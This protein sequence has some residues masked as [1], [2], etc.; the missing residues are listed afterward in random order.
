MAFSVETIDKNIAQML[1]L[2][3]GDVLSYEDYYRNLRELIAK[4]SF[5]SEKFSE[6]FLAF[7]VNERKRVAKKPGVFKTKIKKKSTETNTKRAINFIKP[8]KEKSSITQFITNQNQYQK[9][10]GT[11]NQ[12]S[13][14]KDS[15]ESIYNTL[16]RQ[17]NLYEKIA[18]DNRKKIENEKR[19][20]REEG[21][22]KV[23]FKVLEVAKKILAPF[24]SIFDKII[25][26]ISFIILGRS[27]KLF[28]D[29]TSD[30][31]NKKK[32][33]VLGRFLKDWW[34]ALLGTWF[35]FAHPI[36]RFVRTIIGTV[37]KLTFSLAKTAIPKLISFA[38]TN[39]LIASGAV[40]GIAAGAGYMME[41]NRIDNIADKQ[42]VNPEKR[43]QGNWWSE[44]GKSLNPGQLGMGGVS[45]L[46]KG[47]QI[48][49]GLVGRDTGTTVSGAGPDTQ[50]L[51]IAEGGGAVLQRG[52]VV[53]QKG[54]R[55]RMI[56]KV[57]VDPLAFNIG[58]NANK[59][60]NIG[61]NVLGSAY[62]GLV[63]FSNGGKIGG[64]SNLLKPQAKTIFDRLVK[65]GL[66]PTAAAGIVA[67]IGVETGYTYDPNT[68]QRGGGPGRGL[69]Q[70][71]KGGRFDTDRINLMSFAKSRGT[72]WNNLNTQVDFI[73]HELNTHPEYQKVKSKINKTKD[74]SS[75]T[76]IFLREYEKAGVPHTQDRMKVAQQIIKSGYLNPKEKDQKQKQ[77][78]LMERFS[79]FASNLMMGRGAYAKPQKRMGGGMIVE[80]NTGFN[81]P[82]AT[83][84]RQLLPLIGGGS[85][86]L[87]PG[88]GIV[89]RDVM[90]NIGEDNFNRFI[91]TFESGR[92]SNAAKLGYT[93]PNVNIPNP[94]SRSK[95]N[96]VPITLP[97][98]T[99][100]AGT[101]IEGSLTETK[102]PGFSAVASASID[103]RQNNADM[104]GIVG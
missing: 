64:E 10:Q 82:G 95:G 66:T 93:K 43:G 37:S 81:I 59:P 1:N 98:I 23:K 56:E 68:H 16:L 104:Y 65:G 3:D 22:E 55:E 34:P 2:Q 62:G 7:L 46:S 28:M 9:D 41:K 103:V 76:N 102:V 85:V 75:A 38:K 91:A 92:N 14:I 32:V 73:L 33:E 53:L 78:S 47:G 74:V 84:D 27:L 30:P 48:F 19:R 15:V 8:A 87:H 86:A 36:G 31:Q 51:P 60:R 79:Q 63:G 99:Q 24:Q 67:N 101:K 6:K 42:G 70:W 90:Q 94:P 49:S 29:W 52:E 83:A 54:A 21:L 26:F 13:T 58:S 69:V 96:M 35:L 61:A 40:T 17:Q 4:N 80:E 18:E 39:P 20:K 44:I 89:P 71:E 25:R 50:F 88:E 11:G 97:P 72:P 5:G 57:G 100:S 45:L 77:P 12:F